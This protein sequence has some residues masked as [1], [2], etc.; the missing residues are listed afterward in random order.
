MGQ[1]VTLHEGE[2]FLVDMNC[3]HCEVANE[4][5]S[6]VLFMNL[7]PDFF[8]SDM[9]DAG[10]ELDRFL[11]ESITENNK[12]KRYVI[13]RNPNNPE[14]IE[15][16]FNEIID[17]QTR[18]ESGYEYIEKGLIKRLFG[19]MDRSCKIETYSSSTTARQDILFYEIDRYIR[20]HIATITI[21]DLERTFHFNRNYYNQLSKFSTGMTLTQYLQQTRLEVAKKLLLT[22]NKSVREI[23]QLLGYENRG[24]F[25][26]IFREETG[27]TPAEYKLLHLKQ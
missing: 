6:I 25:Y 1:T 23:S 19:L 12:L 14:E 11:S 15:R 26:R 7:R 4:H 16:I 27:Q 21:Q 24:F 20:A 18:M 13:M 2:S 9:I 3:V 5:D 17:E 22:T 10:N 8:G